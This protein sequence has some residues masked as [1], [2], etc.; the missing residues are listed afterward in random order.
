MET[1]PGSFRVILPTVYSSSLDILQSY[2]LF[3]GTAEKSEERKKNTQRL[4]FCWPLQFPPFLARRREA[5]VLV[6][7]RVLL[8]PT[9]RES[10]L[11]GEAAALDLGAVLGPAGGSLSGN[12]VLYFLSL[13]LG[14]AGFRGPVP[15]PAHVSVVDQCHGRPTQPSIAVAHAHAVFEG[16]AALDLQARGKKKNRVIELTSWQPFILRADLRCGGTIQLVSRW[17]RVT[18]R[19]PENTTNHPACVHTYSETRG[20]TSAPRALAGQ[21]NRVK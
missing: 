7:L 13:L 17:L 1:Q 5:V 4:T 21:S 3:S 20:T 6:F 8:F 10:V 9:E 11:L 18:L 2:D 16:A 12:P 19:L 15:V 14:E